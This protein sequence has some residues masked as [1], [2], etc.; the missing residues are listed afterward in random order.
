MYFPAIDNAIT[1]YLRQ[2]G[3]TQ[4]E[5]ASEIGM[6]SNSLSWKRRG[7]RQWTLD[8]LAELAKVL[9]KTPSELLEIH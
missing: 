1:I 3:S 8:E 9:G 6:S 5:L 7:I 2:T 4:K